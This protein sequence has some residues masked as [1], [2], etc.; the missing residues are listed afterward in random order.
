[1]AKRR[2]NSE[3]SV[4][5]R[6]DGRFEARLSY[7]DPNTGKRKRL[8]VYASTRK[9]AFDNLKEARDRVET[10]A[11]PRDASCTVG[12]WL[13]HWRM[14]TLAA[15]DRRPSTRELYASLC[16]KHLESE[17]FGSIRLDRLRPSQ[18]EGLVL[19]MRAKT[20]PA[21]HSGEAEDNPEPQQV[22]ALS[23]STVRQIYTILRAGLDG[24]VRDGLLARNPAAQ[25]RRPGIQQVEAKHLAPDAVSNLLK[26]AEG[27]RYYAALVLIASTGLRRGE[28]LG[29][30]W[31]NVDLDTGLLKVTATLNRVG[32]KLVCSEP[33]TQRA[34]RTLPLTPTLVNLL[35][36]HKAAQAAE[37]LRAANQ[38]ADSGLV[39]TS[40]LGT[41]VDPRNL[42]RTIEAAATKAG[43]NGVVVHTL[44]HSAA[45]TWLEAGVHI[46]A[47]ADLLGHSSI[48]IT[49][50]T[51]GH[52][53]TDAARAAVIALGTR[54]NL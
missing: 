40:E 4:R 29:L 39:F 26:A 30:S 7:M 19:M 45:T 12:E 14:S 15:S 43:I 35:R 24:A 18:I 49:G 27:S 41:P 3:G 5:Q 28:A 47:V 50:D 34:R 37:R 11:P 52:G 22:R 10:G 23:D 31:K 9:A 16:R 51:Y 53:S 42:L 13:A 33:K 17:P 48:S 25:V 8:S 46:K 2:A 36:K 6:A 1:M 20:R 54:L 38:W 21:K 44:R 32:G